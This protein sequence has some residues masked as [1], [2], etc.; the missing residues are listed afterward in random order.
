[1]C[2]VHGRLRTQYSR[3]LYVNSGVARFGCN[4]WSGCRVAGRRAMPSHPDGQ[5]GCAVGCTQ[6]KCCHGKS[7]V[8][9]FRCHNQVVITLSTWNLEHFSTKYIMNIKILFLTEMSY[10]ELTFSNQR[11]TVFSDATLISLEAVET[12]P[13]DTSQLRGISAD[14]LHDIMQLT[15]I[16]D[17]KRALNPLCRSYVNNLTEST[18]NLQKYNGFTFSENCEC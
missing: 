6:T 9:R 3:L 18:Q 14:T 2:L 8:G 7:S 5:K 15:F 12:V 10:Y 4:W 1:M 16:S 11:R 13:F 17:E